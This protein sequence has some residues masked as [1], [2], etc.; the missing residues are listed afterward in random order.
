VSGIAYCAITHSGTMTRS[1]LL[2]VRR[3][4]SPPI[5][6]TFS[7]FRLFNHVMTRM[8]PPP[9]VQCGACGAINPSEPN[10]LLWCLSCKRCFLTDRDGDTLELHETFRCPF[11]R[12][13][14]SEVFDDADTSPRRGNRIYTP[15]RRIF[16]QACGRSF[17]I[18]SL[19]V[20]TWQWSVALDRDGFLPE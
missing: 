4:F 9:L 13:D 1:I 12:T 5:V 14:L 6:T 18:R 10:E 7:S 16:C 17:R 3:L 15:V 8:D 2:S 19:A 20:Q 11:C